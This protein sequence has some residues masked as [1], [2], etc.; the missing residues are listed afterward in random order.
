[1]DKQFKTINDQIQIQESRHLKILNKTR[2]EQQLLDYNYFDFVNGVETIYLKDSTN[3][4]L[5]YEKRINSKDLERIYKFDK[6][7]SKGIL[8][9]LRYLEIKLKSRISYYFCRQYCPTIT[10]NLNYLNKSYYNRPA[11]TSYS[12]NYFIDFY[13]NNK[14]IFFSSFNSSGRRSYTGTYNFAQHKSTSVRY[15]GR[16]G[17]PPLWVI[18]KQLMFNDL[19]VMTGLLKRNVLKD[20]LQSFG[21][22][23]NDRD[24]F[25]NCLDVFKELRNHCAHY[26]IINR[27]RTNGSINL[28]NIARRHSI[29]P[30]TTNAN[31]DCYRIP[32]FDS[33]KVLSKFTNISE[34]I[35][36][37]KKFVLVNRMMNK[38][39]VAI[40]LL[41]RMGN[42][43]I[44]EWRKIMCN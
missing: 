14:F 6:K 27:F 34:P 37:I 11:S 24:Y 40:N 3:K 31:G 22:T 13:D 43:N 1:M 2:F 30:Q 42:R 36:L 39:K 32:L 23:L 44:K 16:Y 21:L 17:S 41:G 12:G 20:V 9:S 28:K 7:L 19:F 25:L 38:S 29:S 10:D 18:I 35:S 4:Y 5:G 26:E 33:L 15:I 8:D